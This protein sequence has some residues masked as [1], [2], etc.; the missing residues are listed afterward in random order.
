VSS[1]YL[2]P[3]IFSPWQ[4]RRSRTEEGMY[5]FFAYTLKSQQEP[6]FVADITLSPVIIALLLYGFNPIIL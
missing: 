3:V 2:L 4:S 1:Q 6:Y 5:G